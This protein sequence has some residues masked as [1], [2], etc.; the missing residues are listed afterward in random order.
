MRKIS[1]SSLAGTILYVD[2]ETMLDN[3]TLLQPVKQ[4]KRQH[5]E[6]KVLT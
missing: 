4:Q 2:G 3:P 1:F 5:R 6:G